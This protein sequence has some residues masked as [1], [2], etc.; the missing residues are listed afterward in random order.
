LKTLV[1]LIPLW[2][3]YALISLDASIA[4]VSLHTGHTL[5]ALTAGYSLQA[6]FALEALWSFESND[7]A[8]ALTSL[9]T[10]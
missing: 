4:D 6:S 7:T 3:D 8:R 2:T 9:Y 5:I 10:S 1:A